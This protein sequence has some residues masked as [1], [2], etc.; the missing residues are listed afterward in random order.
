MNVVVLALLAGLA[1]D[2]QLAGS[3]FLN[4]PTLFGDREETLGATV[5]GMNAEATFKVVADV[6][7]HI[8]ASIKVCYGCH[9]FAA[10]QAHVDWTVVDEFNV[11]LGRFPVPFGE[12]YLRHDPANH[13]SSS[14]PLPYMMGRMLRRDD[15]NLTIVPEPYPDNGVELYG[16]ARG[17]TTELAYSLY[18]VAGIKGSAAA[19]DLDFIRTRT[20]YFADNNRTPTVGGRMS[21]SFLELPGELWRYMSIGFSAMYGYYDDN[22]ELAYLMAGADFYTRLGKLNVRGEVVMRRTDLPDRPGS[23]QQVLVDRFSQR[24]GFYFQ[25]DGPINRHLEWLGRFDGFRLG[26]PVRLNSGLPDTESSIL[27]YTA[28]LNV[29]PVPGGVKLKLNYEF[30]QFSDFP[31]EHLLHTGLVGTF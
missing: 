15:F 7:E 1:S 2:V 24:E 8:S 6:N 29:I 20:E 4:Q 30:W 18:A 23:F 21:L 12:F 13:R 22:D 3:I 31:E 5:R 10:D 19:G 9:D 17:D 26:A 28:G 14:K 27:R 25:L 16:T 11:R